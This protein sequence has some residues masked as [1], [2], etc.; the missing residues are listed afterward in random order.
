MF[1]PEE[2]A[3][4]LISG[5]VKGRFTIATGFDGFL[6]DTGTNT[7][8][9]I[10]LAFPLEVIAAPLIRLVGGCMGAYF[11]WIC[12]DQL[13]QRKAAAKGAGGGGER[14]EL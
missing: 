7:N 1:Q 14:G 9:P 6:L 3:N 12:R 2:V 8:T 5:M 13:A 4:D 10:N 11:D